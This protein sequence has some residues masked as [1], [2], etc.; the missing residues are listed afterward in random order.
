MKN[1]VI[2][3]RFSSSGQNEQSIESQI[4]TCREFAE[5]QGYNVV[6]TYSDKARTGTNDS[7]PSFQRMIKDARNGAFQYIIV[8][9]FDR[10]A[11][12]RRDSIMYK[13]MLKQDYGIRVLVRD[14]TAFAADSGMG[15]VMIWHF[16]TDSFDPELSLINVIKSVDYRSRC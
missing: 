9:M 1:A 5:N 11:R 10:F 12:N 16:G 13:E 2:Y 3:A 14:K 4:R 8:Y 7:R 6:N 15:G